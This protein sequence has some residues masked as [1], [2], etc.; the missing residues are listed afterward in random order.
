MNATVFTILIAILIAVHPFN[1]ALAQDTVDGGVEGRGQLSLGLNIPDS[2]KDFHGRIG[3]GVGGFPEYEGSDEY[4]VRALPLVDIRHPK[5]LFLKGAS[6][7]TNNGL[8]SAGWTFLHLSYSKTSGSE[9]WLSLGPLVRY[10]GGRDED[11]ADALEGLD[12]VDG[13]VEVGGFMEASAGPWSL[14]VTVAQD[15]SDGHD[16]L[17]VAFGVK[18]SAQLG[19][20]LTIS[21]GP[22]ASWASEH[23]MQSFFGITG[24]QAARTGFA[25]FNAEEGFKDVGLQVRTSYVLSK[26]WVLDGQLGYWHLLGDAADSPL[27]EA[28]GS[29]H[30]IRGLVG[31]AYRF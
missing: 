20:N 6:S 18:Y 10:R 17:L 2:L 28:A 19:D 30:Q 15:V 21:A 12:D 16:G 27:V 26:H 3:L 31:L 23:Y 8:A 11:D 7:D 14:D 29:D 9:A 13:S 5:F 25:I 24:G 4:G 22:T 1:A